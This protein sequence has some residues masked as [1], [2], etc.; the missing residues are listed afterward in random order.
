VNL[1]LIGFRCTG[2]TAV[3]RL[4]A[5]RL[6]MEFV[7]S[8]ERVAEAAGMTIQEIFAAEG[9]RA[10]RRREADT[11][12]EALRGGRRVVATGG[13][14]V[15]RYQTVA[16][17]RREGVVVL[18]EGSVRTIARRMK[19]DPKTAGQRPRLAAGTLEE[20]IETLLSRREPLYRRAADLTVSTER[21]SVEQVVEAVVRELRRAG[22]HGAWCRVGRIPW[23]GGSA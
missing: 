3:G 9:E 5:E 12:A 7:D 19:A 6:G 17:L 13:G 15:L 8:D 10:F 1:V 20:E 21:R 11:I 18:L 16:R 4:L 22:F 2:K 14:A 23:V